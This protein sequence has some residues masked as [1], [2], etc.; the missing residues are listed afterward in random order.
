MSNDFNPLGRNQNPVATIGKTHPDIARH[1]A[2]E[3]W[4]LRRPK[5][6]MQ[7]SE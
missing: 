3:G 2:G 6:G 7:R 1:K 5:G 4:V